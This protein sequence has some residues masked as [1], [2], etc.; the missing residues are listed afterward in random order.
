LLIAGQA[1]T[2]AAIGAVCL[3]DWI[4]AQ[5]DPMRDTVRTLVTRKGNAMVRYA[6]GALQVGDRLYITARADRRIVTL[7]LS[8]LPAVQ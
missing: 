7:P 6:C 4:V 3:Q 1:A 8:A 5:V 2:V